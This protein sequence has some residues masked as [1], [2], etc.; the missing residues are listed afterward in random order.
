MSFMSEA[1]DS[2]HALLDDDGARET[3]LLLDEAQRR[4]GLFFGVRPIVSILRPHFLTDANLA[5]LE[6]VCGVV[7]VA[8]RQAVEHARGQPKLWNRLAFTPAE[9]A[10]MD[11]DPGYAEWSVSSRLDSFLDNE[12][13]IL[14]FVEYNAESP[15]AIAYGDVITDIFFDLP[16][17]REFQ[18]RYS[19]TALPARPRMLQALLDA[20]HEWGGAGD[21][22]IAI[23]DWRGLPTH[24]EFV[25]F[26]R[27]FAEHGIES[28]ICAPEDLTYDGTT[29]RVGDRPIDLVYKRVLTTEF[30]ERMGDHVL[31]HPLVQAYRDHKVCIANNFRA[32]LLHKKSIFALISDD[33]L[34]EAAGIGSE[35]RKLLVQHIPWTRYVERGTTMYQGHEIDLLEFIRA[36]RDHL[37]LKP[38]DDYGGKGVS[39]RLGNQ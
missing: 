2:Y 7:A 24:S 29:L 33:E 20:Y 13:E 4:E 34:T 8:S 31:E 25:L 18:K 9:Q 22:R 1:I 28:V 26:Q 27:Y 21:P 19:V 23:V 30:L 15:A 6:K 39:H 38:N 14:Q 17:M 3:Q 36:E 5:Q 37:V 12:K 32:K 35:E 16:I 11:I 10:V